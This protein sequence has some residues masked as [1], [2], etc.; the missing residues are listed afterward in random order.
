[1]KFVFFSFTSTNKLH[2]ANRIRI[3]SGIVQPLPSV[4]T[5]LPSPEEIGSNDEKVNCV[6]MIQSQHRDSNDPNI[7]L[8]SVYSPTL[9]SNMQINVRRTSLSSTRSKPSQFFSLFRVPKQRG[10][11]KSSSNTELVQAADGV[12][13][14][15]NNNNNSNGN[16]HYTTSNNTTDTKTTVDLVKPKVRGKRN[17]CFASFFQHIFCQCVSLTST[18]TVTPAIINE[19]NTSNNNNNN[20]EELKSISSV[21]LSPQIDSHSKVKFIRESFPLIVYL[22]IS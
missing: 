4:T 11:T 16:N 19:P 21:N 1:M 10:I 3:D 2:K 20:T 15:D 9:P 8:I 7:T 5:P 18:A 12:L 22:K 14:N 6:N 17:S 13:P